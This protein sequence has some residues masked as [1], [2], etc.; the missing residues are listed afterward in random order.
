MQP[1]VKVESKEKIGFSR[2][3]F[4][5]VSSVFR[6]IFLVLLL[7]W[8]CVL[9]FF[10]DLNAVLIKI[11]SIGAIVSIILAQ[12][13]DDNHL[14]KQNRSIRI[15]FLIV[16]ITSFAIALIIL[17][18]DWLNF[19]NVGPMTRIPL[20]IIVRGTFFLLFRL[21]EFNF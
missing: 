4:F 15:A 8:C 21:N 1:D 7:F 3:S 13:T 6:L 12:T 19:F 17:V 5:S 9:F 10:N 16:S 18:L 11:V 14:F 20:N 2:N